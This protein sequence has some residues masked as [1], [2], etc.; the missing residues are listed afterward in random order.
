MK[1]Y[2]DSSKCISCGMCVDMC[3]TV[4]SYDDDRTSKAID[5]DVPENLQK[6]VKNLVDTCPVEAISVQE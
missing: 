2:V 3:P 6:E 5:S 1:V 4:F